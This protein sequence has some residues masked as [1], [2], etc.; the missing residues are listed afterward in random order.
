MT[1]IPTTIEF[2]QGRI[3]RKKIIFFKENRSLIYTNE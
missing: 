3:Q 2:I 1:F